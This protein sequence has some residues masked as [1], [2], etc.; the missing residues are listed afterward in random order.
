MIDWSCLNEVKESI[1]D[2][3]ELVTEQRQ[4]RDACGSKI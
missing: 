3:V 2:L 1:V 4:E